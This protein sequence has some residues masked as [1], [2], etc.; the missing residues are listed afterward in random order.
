MS[1]DEDDRPMVGTYG[2]VERADVVDDMATDNHYSRSQLFDIDLKT[3]MEYLRRDIS[4]NNDDIDA[5]SFVTTELTEDLA[6]YKDT[7]N[8]FAY[9]LAAYVDFLVVEGGETASSAI[10]R[11]MNLIPS[12]I[13][14]TL[15]KKDTKNVKI[16]G[17]V[18]ESTS[19][20]FPMRYKNLTFTGITAY[21]L[22]R[23]YSFYREGL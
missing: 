17:D 2:D 15:V 14:T 20:Y 23:Y 16:G 19:S 10:K 6:H 5:D 7:L 4:D 21:D 22:Y 3:I 11:A 1:D 12:D 18:E 13:R 9:G 8:P